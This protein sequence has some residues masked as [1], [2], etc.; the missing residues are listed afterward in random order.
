[1]TNSRFASTTRPS[2]K[3]KTA[4][5]KYLMMTV[6]ALGTVFTQVNA[7]ITVNSTPQ[8]N[9]DF[10]GTGAP[11]LILP[12]VAT[13][14]CGAGTITYQWYV[15]GA[16]GTSISGASAIVAA[17]AP[18]YS[19]WNT[20]TLNVNAATNLGTST[21]YW[22][23]LTESS[24]ACSVIDTVGP[25][26]YVK[27]SAV[28]TVTLTPSF[29]V[30]EGDDASFTATVTAP[31]PAGI[32]T[33]TWY[34]TPDGGSASNVQTTL[35]VL[36]LTDDYD[37]TT[38]LTDDQD[39]VY[40]DVSNA[41]GTT[42]S[43]TSTVT[44]NPVPD[45]V[46]P[47]GM[48]TLSACEGSN[49]NITYT[50][51]NAVRDASSGGGSVNWTIA[52]SGD[53]PLIALLTAAGNGNSAV[54]LNVG[55]GL[56]PGVYNATI[57]TITNTD[58]GCPRTISTNA[59]NVT[60]Y[61]EPTITFSSTPSNICN[62][63]GS[64]TS[65]D[66]TVANAEYNDGGGTVAV[67]WQAT[68]SESSFAELTNCLGGTAGLLSTTISGTGNG[69][70]TYNIPTTMG[71]GIYEY[72]IT[73]VT[74]TTNGCT[75]SVIGTS[76]IDWRVDPTPNITV[77]PASNSVCEGN[78]NNFNLNVTNAEFCGTTPGVGVHSDVDWSLTYTDNTNSTIGAS[79]LV[80]TGEGSQGPFTTSAALTAGTYTFTPGTI[81]VTSPAAPGCSRAITGNTYTLT[82]NP[83]PS[84]T[85]N[86]ASIT[87]CE[88]TSGTTFSVDV[89]DAELNTVG[90]NWSVS[91][92]A[93][94]ASALSGTPCTAGSTAGIITGS[95][96]GTGNGSTVFTV[97]S[98]LAPGYYTYTLNSIT[99]T[100][101]GCTLG[102]GSV[103]AN[104]TIT[105]IIEPSPII[106]MNPVT[107]DVCENDAESFN[108]SI[109]NTVGC[110]GLG[111]STS[112]DWTLTGVTDN[113]DSDITTQI[114]GGTGTGDQT[115][116]IN[117]NGGG[118]LTPN[119]HMLIAGVYNTTGGTSCGVSNATIDT[120]TLSVD[121]R[122]EI[123]INN[124]PG[125]QTIDICQ[126]DGGSFV[127]TV[128]NA[129]H[130]STGVN[131]EITYS[132]S[133]GQVASGC[134]GAVTADYPGA[135][136]A[137]TGTGN[138]NFSVTIPTNAPVGQY[139]YTVS[140][141]VNTDGPCTGT[142][143][144]VTLG[145][146]SI[147]INVYPKPSFTVQPDSSEVCEGNIAFNDFSLVVSN[148][149]YCS[150]P[151]TI[152]NASWS[153]SGIT[154]NVVSNAPSPITGSGNGATSTYNSN[155]AA[156][157]TAGSYTYT[158][159]SITT[160][161]LSTNCSQS[162]SSNNTHVL[163]VN[164][165]PDA[166]F[167]T[168]TVSVCEGDSSTVSVDVTNAMLNGN[169]VNW[170]YDVTEATGNLTSAC[171]QDAAQNADI[172]ID[173]NGSGNVTITYKIPAG[174][175]PGVYTYQISNVLNT[176]EN[177]TGTSTTSSV[178][179]YVYPKLE[180]SV[181]PTTDSICE[182]ETADFDI[183]VTNARY[184]SALNTASTN[185]PWSLA[186]TDATQS[187]IFPDPLTGSGNSSYT[188]TANNGGL[189][190]AGA[191]QFIT[192]TITGQIVTPT[193][194][195]CP[196]DV[197]DTFTLIVNPEP[198]V[199][200]NQA[201]MSLCQGD[202]GT[203]NYMV[204]NAELLGNG[205]DWSVSITAEDGVISNSCASGGTNTFS[206]TGN[207]D[208][209]VYIG[210]PTNL[211]P[212]VYTFTLNG[213]TNTTSPCTGTV[214]GIPTITIT[215]YPVPDVELSTDSLTVCENT[216][217]SVD[218]SVTNA[219][220]CAS[221][222]G[223]PI[224]VSWEI[225]HTDGVQ[226]TIPASV[227]AGSGNTG[228]TT[229]T[230]NAALGLNAGASPYTFDI[231]Q[232]ENVT[233]SCVNTDSFTGTELVVIVNDLPVLT[234]NSVTP[235]VCDG[236][237]ATI[238]YSVS[239]VEATDGWSFTFTV[240]GTPTTVTGVGPVT[241]VDTFTI[242]LTP[243]GIKT[244]TYSAITNTTTGCVGNT[245]TSNNINVLTLPDVSGFADVAGTDICSGL[246]NDYG[247][248][249]TNS[250]GKNWT[251]WYTIGGVA[252]TWTGTGNGAFTRTTPV[253]GHVDSTGAFDNRP[254]V[255][256]SIGW[257]GGAGTPPLC[258]NTAVSDPNADLNVMPRPFIRLMVDSNVC[259]NYTADVVYTLYG[260]RTSDVWDFDWY[261]TGPT[262]GPNNLTGNGTML[263]D[264]FTT[265]PLNP[266][267]TSN[268][269]VPMVT[270]TSTGCDSSYGSSPWSEDIIVDPPTVPG[271]LS[272]SYTIC[273][274]DVGPFVFTLTGYT[275]DVQ[276][277]DSSDN[278][279]FTWYNIGNTT[280]THSVTNPH[281]TTRYQVIVKS[282]ACPADT[283]NEVI[284]FVHPQPAATIVSLDDSLCEGSNITVVY[285]VTGVEN[286]HNYEIPYT[287][288]DG[289]TTVTDTFTGTGS[290]ATVTEVLTNGGSGYTA[291]TWT[292][293]LNKITNLNTGCDTLLTESDSVLIKTNPVA[294]TASTAADTL[295]YQS[296]GFVRWDGT[297]T[298]GY[299]VKWQKK[300]PAASTWTDI[301]GSAADS[302]EFI[303]LTT[304]TMF[305]A[306]IENAPCSGQVFSTPVTITILSTNPTASWVSLPSS[307]KFCADPTATTTLNYA[308]GGTNGNPWT[309]TLLEGDSTHIITGTGDVASAT[310]TTTAGS[311]LE[312]FNVT[313]VKLVISS[314]TFTCTKNLDNTGI[315][316]I[317]VIDLPSV[318][319]NSVTAQVCDGDKVTMS[320]TVSDI[321]ASESWKL[322]Y[323][324][325][326]VA[327]DT[328]GTGSGT[329]TFTI[330]YNVSGGNATQTVELT[331]IENTTTSTSASTTCVNS[332]TGVT[333]T[334]EVRGTTDPGVIG[335][336]TDVCDGA[337]GF[338]TQSSGSSNGSVITDW[339]SRTWNGTS[340]TSWTSTG[341][342]ST[343]QAY[344]NIS[345]TT[346]YLAVYTNSPC[347]TAHS[348]IVTITVKELPTGTFALAAGSDTICE[349]TT[350]TIEVTVANIDSAQNFTV[351]YVEGSTN[352][353]V[354][355]THNGTATYSFTTGVISS[356]TDITLTKIETTSGSTSC[357][358]TALN[359][360]VTVTVDENPTATIASYDAVLCHGETVDFTVTIGNVGSSDPWTLVATLDGNTETF[361]GTGTGTFSFTTTNTVTSTSDVL[362]LVSVTN[363]NTQD[364][365]V[366]TLTESV[367]ITVDPTTVAGVIGTAA[368]S[369]DTIVCLGDGGYVKE[370]TAGTGNITKWQSRRNG[371]STWV[372]I[373][374]TNSTQF[375]FN[376]TDT[377]EYR[378]VYQ[379]GVCSSEF[380]NI[381]TA[382][383]KALPEAVITTIVDD[384]ICAG[385]T[386]DL[387]FTVTNVDSG[388]TFEI[389]YTEGSVPF[390]ATY[391]QNASGVH[392]ITTDALTATTLVQ[393]VSIEVLTTPSAS[394]PACSNTLNSN[395]TVTVLDLPFASITA[396]P[397]TLCQLDKIVFTVTVTNVLATDNWMLRYELENDEDTITGTGPGSVTWIDTDTNTAES[398][399]IQLIEIL[400]TSNL[401]I[402]K[403]VNTDDWDIYIFKP[404]EPGEI[405]AS[406]DTICKG[407]STTI[408]EVTGTPKQGVTVSW[409]YKPI[410]ASNWTGLT[411]N[412]T[413]LNIINL[414]ETTDYRAVYKSGVCDTA[415]SNVIR[416][417]VEELP[418]AT[419]SGS[420]AICA[421]DS[422]DLTVNISNVGTGQDWEL[423]YLVGTL[424]YQLDGS[425]PGN[426]TLRVGNLNTN[427][428]VIL[429]ELVTTSGTPQCLNDKL[430][431][432]AQARVNINP[433]P[434][435][436]LNSVVSPVCQTSTSS[437]SYTVSNVK[438]GDSWTLTYEVDDATSGSVTTSGKGP[439]TFTIAT[440]ALADAKTYVVN[441]LS[442]VNTTTGC[443]STLSSTMDI[444]SDATTTPGSV[445][446]DST[447][448]F[449]SHIGTINHTGGNGSIIRWETSQDG[450]TS[451]ATITNTN[452]AYT[453]T[454]LTKTSL[455]RVYKKNGVCAEAATSPVTI[456]VN[457]LP[458]AVISG[459]DT[460]C[461]GSSAALTV[462]VTNTQGE[463][464]KVS[465]LVGTVLDTISVS[466]PSTTGTINTGSIK[467]NTDVTLK[468]VW[469]TSGTP[470]CENNNLNNNA[471]ATIEVDDEPNATLISLTDSV[472][473]G[474]PAFGKVTISD[475][476]T[477][478]NWK[479][480]WSIN[481]GAADSATGTGAGSF[482]ITTANL[483]V[484]PSVLRLTR[485]INTT[486]GCEGTPTDQDFVIVSPATVGGTLA[487]TDTVCNGSNNGT[488]TLGSDANGDILRWEYSTNGGTTWTNINNTTSTYSYSNL[489]QTTTYRVLVKS[490][491]C[492]EEYSSEV[493]I[494][495][496]ELPVAEIVSV[497][498]NRIC[499][500][501]ST[502]VAINVTNVGA[503][504]DWELKYLQGSSVKYLTGTGPGADT[505]WT[506]TLSSTTVITL[507]TMEITSGS[508][509]CV[510]TSFSNNY[511]TTITI[512]DNPT[513]TITSYPT[514]ICKGETPTVT[515]LVD[516]V[517]STEAW[518]VI[519][520][521]N[522]GSNIT[523]TGV[524]SGQFNL[525]NMPQFNTEGPNGVRLMTITNTTSNPNCTS[526][527][528]DSVTI[529]VDSTSLGGSLSGVSIVCKG[530]GGKLTLNGYRGD[531]QKWQ[532]STDGINFYDVA[533]TADTLV[534]SNLTVKTWYRVIVMNGVCAEAT[535]TVKA[536]D[537]QELPTVTIN[538]PSIDICSGEEADI[539]LTIGNA[540]STSTWTIDY[541]ENGTAGSYTTGTGT[542]ETITFGPY[543]S[544]TT[545][546]ITGI[547]LTNGLGCANTISETAVVTVTP[548]PTATIT[549][550]PDSLCEGDVLTYTVTVDDVAT[551]TNWEL[552]YEV[553]GTA[554]P[555]KKGK[556]AGTFTVNTGRTVSPNAV[557]LKLTSIELDNALGCQ[558]DLDDST[559]I[560]VS[561]TSVGGTLAPSSTTICKGGSAT[562]TLSGETGAVQNWEYSTDNGATWAVLS[563]KAK[564]V[565]ITNINETTLYRV[566]VKS[567]TCSG[568][569]STTATV[570]VI[571]TPNAT[572]TSNAKVCPGDAA[573]FT[574]HVTDVAATDGWSVVYTRNGATVGTPVTG[575]G[576]G[577]FDFTVTGSTYNGNPTYITVDLVSITN[578]THGCVNNDLN[579]SA[580]AR[581]TPNPVASFTADNSC[582]DTTVVFNNTS[583]IAEGTITTYKWF[584]GD[585][586]SS[587]NGSPSHVYAA[588][589]TYN[590]RLVVW[591]D[592][593]C[594]GEVTQTITIHPNPT[595]D[596]T[597]SNVCKN[598]VFTATDQSTVN[599]GSIVSWFWTFGDGST[600]TAQNPSHTYAASGNYDVTL[601]VVTDNGCSNTVSKEVTV[602][603]LPEANFV[604]S[605]VCEDAPMNFVNAS[606]IGYGTM[607]YEWDFAGQ[608]TSTDKD[609]SFTFTGFGTFSVRLIAT[610][611]NG[612]KD[613]IDRNVTV[614]PAPTA[615]F[616]VADVCIGEASSFLNAS[617][618]PAP[619]NIVEYS[620]DFGDQ[621]GNGS[622]LENPNYTYA[623]SGDYNVTLR[624]KSDR[625][626]ENTVTKVA[627]VIPLPDVQLT[628]QGPTEFCDGD[629]VVLTANA[630]ART[631]DWSWNNGADTSD[632]ASVTAKVNGWYKVRITAPPIGCANE[633]SIFVTVHATPDVEAWLRDDMTNKLDT[634]DKGSFIDLHA[635]PGYVSYLWTPNTYLNRDDAA[636]VMASKMEEQV[637]YTVTITD[638]FGCVNSADVTVVVRDVFNLTVYNT[639]T[640]NGDGENDT[641]WIENIWAYPEAEVIIFNRYG[642]EV[643][644][645]TGYNNTWDATYNGNEL[646]DGAYYYVIV[647]PDFPDVVYKGALNVIREKN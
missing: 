469:M 64:G 381:V 269:N 244:V 296:N 398:A 73:G 270:N 435:A 434:Y 570:T 573:T 562:L 402:C 313:L 443:D 228:P 303:G 457:E 617:T 427:S 415:H 243:P 336:S 547:T 143:D 294:S 218:L 581:V 489:T 81:T 224:A 43:S 340:W 587:V 252:S 438:S 365:C 4:F 351:Y 174:L 503:G 420:T 431:N 48:S 140:N 181:T 93:D 58:D 20:S 532:V 509:Q 72:T 646:P 259:V 136:G 422:V 640:A 142:V 620:W 372:D 525:A 350:A 54:N 559:E 40:V 357:S 295:C 496:N 113:V 133:S 52:F 95:L 315:A 386:A 414:Q 267:G 116:T 513:A 311:M 18:N 439:G 494:V 466:G 124:S 11:S 359:S 325:N 280:D 488:L 529:N 197:P 177:C 364:A 227:W 349:G 8:E 335:A 235:N 110:S 119:D 263:M 471:T 590:V 208:S 106:T 360:T 628:A 446:S 517:L 409:E 108:L 316:N 307:I 388:S 580:S 576:S 242:A 22:A 7:A 128:S 187:N 204:S 461:A 179:I 561:P 203:F 500:G 399:K 195:N 645:G 19:G 537:I 76:T 322:S 498:A 274:G 150:D 302:I 229:Y 173:T 200:F 593:G 55:A 569:Y 145:T 188:F 615:D 137:Y 305:R 393:L 183:D 326:G 373:N 57:S 331:S 157:L 564:S 257:T 131:W 456:T 574:L 631:Y 152:A 472:C 404:T 286:T 166:S 112:A 198:V 596:F 321:K 155:T 575:T 604:A 369:A 320:V 234:I 330:P 245:P 273:D 614:Y 497:G 523:S 91:Y 586:D 47:S 50:V 85:F 94:G 361:T 508:P 31:S 44:V 332:L 14:N 285:S 17:G 251:I 565:T 504:M 647:H 416:I 333:A 45:V 377:T 206:Q 129:E 643:F 310:Y 132:E 629:S 449:A 534:F 637:T 367:T 473:T 68:I 2:F 636:D 344:V 445:A 343:S 429:Q 165:A 301:S 450:G 522:G 168:A 540:T 419:I 400:N 42:T 268:V 298:D 639:V 171:I 87:Q 107:K 230:V 255:I 15:D 530:D 284:L 477:S 371:T 356:T 217:G 114:P 86:T 638:E 538:N 39:D 51:S 74:N 476:R 378:A 231:A 275:G 459:S 191:Y 334:Y 584:F 603:I 481:G 355:F 549:S 172:A 430:T 312:S 289:S 362:A 306:V 495:V 283:S 384:S 300:A 478:E 428:D 160:T 256:D 272:P 146:Q 185:V 83:N 554:G 125:N 233:H 238:N 25:F 33:Y 178:T 425:G 437:F 260:L 67:N 520:K 216:T 605:P 602:Y 387:E 147:T 535:S 236:E 582:E 226:S 578:T 246:T 376:L 202:T 209:T 380:S 127:F 90:Q 329:F 103:G 98:T 3:F 53:A 126:G 115:Y 366:S 396:G 432:N 447:V 109:T 205:V 483:T 97:P 550:V 339:R 29:D 281:L 189:L 392:T 196:V 88:G 482:N 563:N 440:P 139:I 21:T 468:K 507:Q 153:I 271:T 572:V 24:G 279:G 149:Q 579:S 594:R 121:P 212:G 611:N 13:S 69:T 499:E 607:T 211:E 169:P 423:D 390:T 426:H 180:V 287:L 543:T 154:D 551:G 353:S 412:N 342:S 61:P 130:N 207:G 463:D 38:V 595:A 80:G 407:G 266:V 486:T 288:T 9:N 120:F 99:N 374:S 592:N 623:A 474:S 588:A 184:C 397:D 345:N 176:D 253:Q 557:K 421:G 632:A 492:D 354:N 159:T 314:G 82:V 111:S 541:E 558:T 403:S 60:I 199:T 32:L 341:N 501:S 506:G 156:T 462:S 219:E 424:Y 493:T 299:V 291:G 222:G 290:S 254:L 71:V 162:I 417:Q 583:S 394:I 293:T 518:T 624:V 484:N 49:V 104:P 26:N 553:D 323:T 589:G 531:I 194:T 190:T 144:G 249:V 454:N 262:D 528:T 16:G 37:Y 451:W 475:V 542:S 220:Y 405:A 567:G 84:V 467:T 601:T 591:S 65:F 134:N 491:A 635:T 622:V 327:M 385:E 30:C 239:D 292:L 282:G 526:A 621:S 78:S 240:S 100:S 319:L 328:T 408:S 382:T 27:V 401:G 264:T 455:F 546:E 118:T 347:D 521:V 627:S 75:G 102:A 625:G 606:A 277:W 436:S 608:G 28:P 151:S 568:A 524:G 223:A 514:D 442:I 59:I 210:V 261:T 485:L 101:S 613:T 148:A 6:L 23:I 192:S 368:I 70:V 241:G 505:I 62:G 453:Y 5:A 464:W 304:T 12:V 96:T 138:G 318:S 161:G 258:K 337:S 609:P 167:A 1:M 533:N 164:P 63:S 539:S 250:A 585:G 276:N 117:V 123:Q 536:V 566:F 379:S 89:T 619:D 175:V 410:S 395:G 555:T 458:T 598:E 36:T 616:T 465:Y 480:Y 215:I 214:G 163:T 186:Y 411:N 338:V 515:I 34:K 545:I 470:Q 56:S 352:K 644:R 571:P 66:I 633:D 170:S 248:T 511:V 577:D 527:L 516:D 512:I 452:S 487:G 610:S 600:S 413:T 441:L 79:P 346:Q 92:T 641:W 618:V 544:T 10:C 158:A 135:S 375:F 634:V 548:N 519:Y 213:I 626:C 105:I 247:F 552:D 77:I 444:V 630:N 460:I 370:F 278:D 265:L 510:N 490:G 122:P 309:L 383:P 448:C 297:A 225:T 348:N 193:A 560:K 612:C 308:I 201:T 317:T 406:V 182:G 324:I 237:S 556:G 642:M 391:T 502:F 479:V 597:F 418:L 46:V 35:D 41:C 363:N 358:N 232:V 433:R 599:T 389:E 141:I 221:I